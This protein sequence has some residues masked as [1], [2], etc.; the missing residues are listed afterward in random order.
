MFK[1]FDKAT[2]DD[3]CFLCVFGVLKS[4]NEHFIDAFTHNVALH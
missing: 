4:V 3:E 1:M 2:G